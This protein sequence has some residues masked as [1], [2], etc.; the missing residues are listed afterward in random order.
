MDLD[1]GK[2]AASCRKH[3]HI[4]DGTFCFVELCVTEATEAY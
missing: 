1:A 2:S 3:F 4:M